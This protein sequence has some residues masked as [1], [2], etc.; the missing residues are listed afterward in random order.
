MTQ[1]TETES[2]QAATPELPEEQAGTGLPVLF[3]APSPHLADTDFTTRRMMLDVL[4][5]LFPVV[6]MSLWFFHWGAVVQL[7]VCVASCLVFEALFARMQDKPAPLGDL[8]AVVTGVILALSLPWSAPFYVGVV[9]SFIAI[10]IGKAAFG[11][12]GRNIFNPAM[13]GRAF[14]MLS[15][16]GVMGASAYV[17]ADAIGIITEATPLDAAKKAA[18][19]GLHLPELWFLFLGQHNGS[20]GETSALASVMGGL[21]LCWRRSASWEIPVGVLLATVVLGGGAHWAGL[22][23]LTVLQQTA[24]GALVFGAF[25][26]ATDPVS[27]PITPKGKFYFGLGVGLFVIVFRVFSGYP[28]GL[29]FAVLMMNAVV[30]LI[31]RWTIPTP[32]GGPVPQRA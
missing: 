31:N 2:P 27:S 7:A 3:V 14:V 12:L 22:T 13:V 16:A 9:G 18:E 29:M 11:G 8:S 19:G 24:S 30:P 26:I 1:A 5:G 6:L 32:V 17:S 25:F 4:I 23:P 28:E 21:Y 20:L 10:G 15:F